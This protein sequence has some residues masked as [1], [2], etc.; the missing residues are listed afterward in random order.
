[1]LMRASGNYREAKKVLTRAS[2]DPKV[3]A[4]LPPAPGLRPIASGM[5]FSSEE[6][7]YLAAY[8]LKRI[9]IEKKKRCTDHTALKKLLGPGQYRVFWDRLQARDQTLEEVASLYPEWIGVK[10]AP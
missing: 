5:A 7:V 1:M 9:H 4:S 2:N 6:G 3:R 10:A 8:G